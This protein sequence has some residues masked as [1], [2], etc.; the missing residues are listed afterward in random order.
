M[1][2]VTYATFNVKD[3]RFKNV[4]G[5]FVEGAFCYQTNV[6]SVF[7]ISICPTPNAHDLDH[8]YINNERK[9]FIS[10][11]QCKKT[12]NNGFEAFQRKPHT[13]FKYYPN[14]H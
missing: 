6:L 5:H 10:C 3:G 7:T 14:T 8:I 11:F 1:W 9:F 2:L 13:T 12:I 4:Y